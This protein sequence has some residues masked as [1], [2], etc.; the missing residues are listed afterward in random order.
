MG[1]AGAGKMGEISSQGGSRIGRCAVREG[2]GHGYPAGEAVGKGGMYKPERKVVGFSR[3]NGNA[4]A[5]T[6]GGATEK[7]KGVDDVGG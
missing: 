7:K 6:S 2:K 5:F 1:S 4:V 3:F